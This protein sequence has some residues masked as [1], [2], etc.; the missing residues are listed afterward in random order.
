MSGST[1]PLDPPAAPPAAKIPEGLATQVGKILTAVLAVLAALAQAG[2]NFDPQTQKF[3]LLGVLVAG[4]LMGG[5]YWQAAM[6]YRAGN[7]AAG[8][9][10]ALSQGIIERKPTSTHKP[11]T[12][13]RK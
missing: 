6:K 13:A 11:T 12:R 7:D 1:D 2:V 10:A 5:R 8:L 9:S 4:A 3:V